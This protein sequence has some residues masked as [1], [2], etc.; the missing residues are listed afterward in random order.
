MYQ[1]TEEEKNNI[2][3]ALKTAYQNMQTGDTVILIGDLNAQ[4]G[5]RHET[6]DLEQVIKNRPENYTMK[7]Q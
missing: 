5:I 1:P 7:N 4:V 3:F 2:Y 6:L